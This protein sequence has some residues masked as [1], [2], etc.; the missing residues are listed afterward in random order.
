M[1]AIGVQ[2]M[3]LKSKV[4]QT[5]P[6]ETLRRLTEVGFRAVEV[7]Q[8]P[9][10]PDNVAEMRRA[11]DELG[12]DFGALSAAIQT[13][14]GAPNDSL[15]TDFDKV[16]GD[17]RTLGADMVRIGMMPFEAMASYDELLRFCRQADDTAVRL[18]EV[19]IGLYYHNHH[20]EFAKHG[21]EL[22]LDIIREKA[23]NL[24]LEI[25]VHWVQRGG[26]DPVRTLQKYAGLVDLVHLKDYRIGP[27]DPA[28]FE[29]LRAGDVVGFMT[30]FTGVVQFAEVGEG[31]L[32]WPE[33]IDTAI[34]SGAKY[35][36]IEQDE[37]YGRDP[38][39]C[40]V[41]SRENLVAAGYEALL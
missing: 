30:A 25:D 29:A 24:R 1:A 11:R 36:F 16:V 10:S 17:A 34:A 33:I 21:G 18:A 13:P 15:T 5:G 2:M 27:L 12:V 40:L 20:I 3:M 19:G 9:M 31:T 4:E 39:D 8:I 28:A 7:S 22:I 32:D 6:Y 35:L 23:P 14:V 41:T 38:F 37:Q 26:R